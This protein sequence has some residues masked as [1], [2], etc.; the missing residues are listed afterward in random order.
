MNYYEQFVSGL[1]EL[2]KAA[3]SY[4]LGGVVPAATARVAEGAPK[5]LIFSPHPDD[6]VIIGALPLRL[7]R[8]F[9]VRV[10]NVAVT[11]GSARY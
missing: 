2:V 9:G 7:L 5:V 3:E 8:E 1:A 6:E 4:P 11:L 10:V